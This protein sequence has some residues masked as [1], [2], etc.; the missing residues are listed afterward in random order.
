MVT[1]G[2]VVH[3]PA[4]RGN[5]APEAL[6]LLA[7]GR[8]ATVHDL[9]D[10]WVLRR[11]RDATADVAAE[12][13]ALRLAARA[14]IPVPAVRRAEGP[15]LEMQ[16]VRGPSLL[17]ALLAHP[18]G[19]GRAGRLL[20]DLH[21]RLDDVPVPAGAGLPMPTGRPGRLLHGDLH[22]GNVLLPATGPVLIDW[23]DAGSGPSAH[24]T[25]TTWLVLA[26][27]DPDRPDAR[28]RLEPLRRPLLAAFLDGIDRAAAVDAMPAVAARRLADRATSEGERTRIRALLA[29]HPPG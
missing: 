9:G 4:M 16:R 3:H 22:P 1:S 25:A 11:C 15:D 13:A 10:G 8:S 6:R 12:A 14:G 28:A 21:R 5:E 18:D 17:S 26:C 20:A 7:E 19:A 29:A 23:T 27:F 24:D 2:P